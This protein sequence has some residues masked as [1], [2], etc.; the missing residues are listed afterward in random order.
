MIARRFHWYYHYY[1]DYF[2]CIRSTR[3]VGPPYGGVRRSVVKSFTAAAGRRAAAILT[4]SAAVRTQS[5]Y[6]SFRFIVFVRVR[7]RDPP[8]P[9]PVSSSHTSRTRISRRRDGPGREDCGGDILRVSAD[10]P[11]NVATTT[12]TGHAT[13]YVRFRRHEGH[14]LA[15][16]KRSRECASIRH[17]LTRPRK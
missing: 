13:I 5:F 8:G 6:V 15:R 1:C 4:Y 11:A 17:V 12:T 16:R 9:L 2:I 7:S 3:N 10:S 14:G